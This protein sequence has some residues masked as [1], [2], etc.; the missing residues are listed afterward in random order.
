MESLGSKRYQPNCLIGCGLPGCRC[1]LWDLSQEAMAWTKGPR[2]WIGLFM[3]AAV[4]LT[5]SQHT[6]TPWPTAISE[7]TMTVFLSSQV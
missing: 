5:G 3:K 2:C 6:Q 1:V 4:R 7:A